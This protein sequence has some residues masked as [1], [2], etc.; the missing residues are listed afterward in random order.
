MNYRIFVGYDPREAVAFHVCVNSIIRHSSVPVS[1]TPLALTNIQDYREGHKDASNQFVYSRFL[2]P[3]LCNN[4]GWAL[5]IDGDMIV[6]SDIKELFD[7]IEP[8]KAVMVVKHNYKTRASQK[9]LNSK[10][11]DYPRKNWSSVVLWNCES[12]LNRSLKPEFIEKASGS[13]LHRFSWLPDERIGELPLEWNWLPQEFGIWD[14]AKLIHYTLGTP[15]FKEYANDMMA[16]DWHNELKLTNYC[17][18]R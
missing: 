18:Q 10:N 15:C 4:K 16:E 12:C 9:Y 2:I 14:R 13:D 1:I 5:F 8:D 6:K 11:Q 7:L 17:Q 3:H